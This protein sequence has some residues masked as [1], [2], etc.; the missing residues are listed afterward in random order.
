MKLLHADSNYHHE[1]QIFSYIDK[2]PITENFYDLGACLGVFSIHAALRGIRTYSFEVDRANF[3]GLVDNI[4]H[5]KLDKKITPFNYGVSDGSS[6]TATLLI[7][8]G[9][10]DWIGAHGRTLK[11]PEEKSTIAKGDRTKFIHVQVPVDSL[12]HFVERFS[13]PTPLHAKVD[14][15]GSELML[16]EGSPKS[17]RSLKSLIIEIFEGNPVHHQVL[18]LINSYGFEL[19]YKHPISQN[20]CSNYFNCE[21]WKNG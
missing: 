11:L 14:I 2:I 9:S 13:L 21:F 4:K 16:L 7:T 10:Q 1:K 8:P 19:R 5:N 15:D 3:K 6:T 17:F 18:S 20:G 12:D